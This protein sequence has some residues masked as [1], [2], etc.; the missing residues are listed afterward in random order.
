M[1]PGCTGSCNVYA[2][3]CNLGANAKK[4]AFGPFFDKRRE[5]YM[6]IWRW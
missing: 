4:A 2:S 3:P 6:K 1:L 5:N